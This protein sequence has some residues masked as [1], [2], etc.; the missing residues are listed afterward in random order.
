MVSD[1]TSPSLLS[2]VRDAADEVAWREFDG[3]YGELIVRFCCRCGL[4][5]PDAEDI[6]QV[7]MTKLAKALRSF[8]YS[9]E[10][11]RF[12]SYLGCVVRNEVARHFSHPN[13][14]S[15]EVDTDDVDAVDSACHPELSE[16]QWEREWVHH[17]LRLAMMTIRETFDARSVEVFE[18]LLRG[19]SVDSAA[20]SF[21]MTTQAVHKV[22]QRIRSR[23]KQIVAAQIRDEEEPDG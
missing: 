5:H 2:R 14:P 23:L 3:R 11:G 1:T 6:R 12:R 7:V 13:A 10:R 22:K 17:H 4:Q 15:S 9:R 21:S 18:C 8:H 19:D 16:E 20:G